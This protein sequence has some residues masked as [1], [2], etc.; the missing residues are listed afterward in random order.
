[1]WNLKLDYT[2]EMAT[3]FLL[4]DFLK[5]IKR[6]RFL[7]VETEPDNDIG[8]GFFEPLILG[9]C[10]CDF[11][12]AL[13][14]G[15]GNLGNTERSKKYISEVLGVLNPRYR[16]AA[17]HLVKNYRNGAVHA[18]APDGNFNI[19]LNHSEAHLTEKHNP[20]CLVVSINDFLNDL[21]KSVVSFAES[22]N[23]TYD[24]FGTLDSLNKAR[25]DLLK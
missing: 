18:Y 3:E 2:V 21:E 22:I 16:S 15:D 5:I 20:F 19:I 8:H 24:G 11:L 7:Y 23:A 17:K 6:T 9:L 13:Y 25:R 10:W 1:M 14:Y 12:G 4:N